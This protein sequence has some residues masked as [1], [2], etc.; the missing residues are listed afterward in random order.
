MLIQ[1]LIDHPLVTLYSVSAGLLVASVFQVVKFY[2]NVRTLPPGPLPLPVIG[3]ILLFL[4]MGDRLPHELIASLNEKYG[5]VFTFWTGPMPL[6]IITDAN[7]GKEALT[8]VEFAGRPPL[9]P[10]KEIFFGD[11]IDIALADFGRE[12]EVLR[13]VSHSAVRKFAVSERLPLIIDSRVKNFL[14]EITEQN[15]NEPFDPVEYTSFLMMSLLASIA[16]GRQFTMSDPDFQS[17]NEA[18][19]LQNESQN[20][21]MLMAFVPLLKYIFR[22]E[23]NK[24]C[25]AIAGLRGFAGRQYQEHQKSY[26]EGVIRDFLDAII[27]AKKEAEAE[28]SS[29]TKYL[30]DENIVSS[31]TDLFGAGSETTKLTL[32]WVFLF[33][34]EYPQ[35]Q[36]AIRQEVEDALG[37]DEMPTLEHR[38]R[39]NLL[40]AFIFE[41]L[42]MRTILPTGLPHKAVVD[43]ELAGHKIKKNVGVLILLEAGSKDKEAWGDPEVF[44]PERFLDESGKFVPKPNP[45]F[46]PF[47]SGRRTCLGEKLAN[48]NSF[49]IVSGIL[50]QTKDK[51][52]AF[53]AGPGSVDL[54]P[55]TQSDS[56]LRPRS[57]KL[58]FTPL[59][60]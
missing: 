45:L 49:L 47:G 50:H 46:V 22:K 5:P 59:K 15:G 11:S 23:Y 43:T 51:L 60:N 30:K 34:A 2:S 27:A 32:L 40:Q 18:V 24:I 10:L 52:L 31:V 55:T 14:R 3:N 48:A 38:P 4:K 13:K 58:V 36:R 21:V 26:K 39:C 29:D 37:S 17:L 42:R 44:R 41:T 25:K 6:I 53:P 35:Y 16:F 8:R 1:Y 7:L 56:N 54:R 28:D 33:L 9:G 57:Y 20:K 19:K 12:W